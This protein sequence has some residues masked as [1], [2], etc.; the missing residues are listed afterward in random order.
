MIPDVTELPVPVIAPPCSVPPHL[1]FRTGPS[2]AVSAARPAP[3]GALRK[4]VRVP[5]TEVLP[6]PAGDAKPPLHAAGVSPRR[7]RKGWARSS[8][9][10]HYVD[11]V[12]VTGSIPVAPTIPSSIQISGCMTRAYGSA[13]CRGRTARAKG[14]RSVPFR[15]RCALSIS[16]A[17]AHGCAMILA[18]AFIAF[19][20]TCS[21]HDSA[22]PAPAGGT[23][24]AGGGTH[25]RGSRTDSP[26]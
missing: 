10:E 4:K 20:S 26:A 17:A 18:L 8:A 3:S 6:S 15:P 23:T 21:C 12:G 9:G 16:P 19:R 14:T 13:P 1:T 22:R 11:I 7:T 2:G 5:A 25:G 24:G